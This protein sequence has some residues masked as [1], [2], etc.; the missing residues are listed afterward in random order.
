VSPPA[1]LPSYGGAQAAADSY[2]YAEQQR[3]EAVGAQAALN[4]SLSSH[5]WHPAYPY[6]YYARFWVAPPAHY[7]YSRA[8]RGIGLSIGG[9][10]YGVGLT[11]Y[12]GNSPRPL[13]YVETWLGPNRYNYRPLSAPSGAAPPAAPNPYASLGGSLPG[14][15]VPPPPK[16]EVVPAPESSQVAGPIVPPAGGPEALPAPPPES[17]PREF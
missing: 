13:G 17:G 2:H 6:D 7:G 5:H 15:P 16:A 3:R 11:G 8:Y 1:N 10:G 4:D 12:L 9:G 14:Q